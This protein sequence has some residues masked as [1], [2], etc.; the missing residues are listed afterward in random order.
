VSAKSNPGD[1]NHGRGVKGGRSG[2]D[3]PRTGPLQFLR[4]MLRGLRLLG[5][6]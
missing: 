3:G 4:D 6:S 1:G 5:R 2:S